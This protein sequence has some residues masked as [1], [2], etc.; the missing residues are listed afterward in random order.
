LGNV[1]VSLRDPLCDVLSS[2]SPQAH[3]TAL[4]LPKINV[5]DVVQNG[6]AK[7]SRC[8]ARAEWGARR[9]WKVR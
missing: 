2:T 6:A 1:C 8:Q 3:S 9:T 5:S 4:T 7:S